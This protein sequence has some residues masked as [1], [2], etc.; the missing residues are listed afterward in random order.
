M[1][2]T[3]SFDH[4]SPSKK[5]RAE[6]QRREEARKQ[7]A[8]DL[9]ND[10]KARMQKV[11]DKYSDSASIRKRAD[12]ARAERLQKS[13]EAERETRRDRQS[14]KVSDR[15]KKDL[16]EF[17]DRI[18]R[19]RKAGDYPRK[20]KQAK[21]P[22]PKDMRNDLSPGPATE[23]GAESHLEN[24]D[25]RGRTLLDGTIRQIEEKARE[26]KRRKNTAPKNSPTVSQD[27]FRNLPTPE[28]GNKAEQ[29]AKKQIKKGRG[30]QMLKK[31]GVGGKPLNLKN[32][33]PGFDD[34]N[35]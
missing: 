7:Q 2:F 21:K 5:K 35:M 26:E 4:E 25:H 32:S 3:N 1:T 30:R 27:K 22:E 15:A 10:R 18:K 16:G 12:K 17:T 8:A 29:K 33:F 13:E 34:F 28:L 24:K 6:K 9:E 19:L 20:S 23:R 11:R 14:Q 31:K